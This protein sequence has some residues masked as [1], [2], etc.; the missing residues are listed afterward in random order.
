MVY[1][2]I[3]LSC[4]FITK[5][6]E[7]LLFIVSE[8]AIWDTFLIFHPVLFLKSLLQ[9]CSVCKFYL[10]IFMH[11]VE[12]EISDNIFH[13]QG[14]YWF[15][16]SWPTWE[17]NRRCVQM[18]SRKRQ[19][20]PLHKAEFTRYESKLSWYVEIQILKDFYLRNKW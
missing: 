8:W 1:R 9:V 11:L 16:I 7:E 4:P 18:P 6:T 17:K 12:D 20:I 10:P 13:L 15:S 14:T 5:E 2:N 19:P 3:F